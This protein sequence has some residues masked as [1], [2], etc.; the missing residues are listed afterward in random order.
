MKWLKWSLVALLIILCIP[1]WRLLDWAVITIADKTFTTLLSIIWGLIF[2]YLP[3]KL[4]IP[5]LKGK[6]GLA[7]LL[8]LGLLCWFTEPL[9]KYSTLD[10]TLSHCGAASY[11]GF[12]YNLKPLLSSAHQDDLELRNQL[13]W[14]RKMIRRVPE[15][16]TKEELELRL[17]QLKHIL[18]KPD[19]KYRIS[20]PAVLILVGNYI[21]AATNDNNPIERALSSRIFI[22]SL[23]FWTQQY[24]EEIAARQYGWHEWP[25]SW[26]IKLEY[27]F[28]EKNWNNIYLKFEL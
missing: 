5:R 24:S 26:L 17:E 19:S 21:S 18:L 1:L 16:I 9:S 22:N 3:L 11:T 25:H 13:C 2:V 15:K 20:L 7:F 4:S 12:F 14:V 23:S 8:M 27:G 6:H 10:P 28:L